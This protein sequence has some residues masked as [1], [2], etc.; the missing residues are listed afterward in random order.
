MKILF[1]NTAEPCC[2]VHQYGLN[3]YQV[4]QSHPEIQTRYSQA[5]SQASLMAEVEEF[6][7]D[8]ITYNWSQ[9]I[10]GWISY[11][12]FAGLGRQA[13]F[14][15]D[16]A[17]KFG[18]Y[19]AILFSDPTMP[20]HENWFP[21]G[22]PIPLVTIDLPRPEDGVITIGVNGFI[23]AWANRVVEKAKYDFGSCRLRLHLPIAPY[24]DA[25]GGLAHWS[26]DYCRSIAGDTPVEICHDFLSRPDLL[27]WLARNHLNC[28]LRDPA[29]G[30]RGV[31]SVTDWALAVRRPL[32]ISR[33]PAFR[34]LHDCS[35]SLCAEDNSLPFLLKHSVAALAPKYEQFEPV[36]VAGQVKQALELS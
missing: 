30:W 33:S 22:R 12:P 10:G 27:R 1:V 15:H 19:S 3:M 5:D 6:R 26:A 23:G 20:R 31:S 11:A 13:L 35:P 25:G 29:Q 18:E 32:A 8:A 7:P 16:G 9:L 14:Y 34:H 28:Y 36:R 17:A 2:G 21:I 24:G 4:L